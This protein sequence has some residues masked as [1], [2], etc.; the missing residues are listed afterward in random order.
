MQASIPV[1]T[2]VGGRWQITGVLGEGG[3][4]QVLLAVDTSEV[5]LGEAAVKV[6]H[7]GTTPQERADFLTEVKKIAGLRH[8]NL[9]GYLD[10]GQL[11]LPADGVS[12]L[13]D[14]V[15]PFLVTERCAM[16]LSD[17]GRRSS[18]GALSPAE[19]LAVLADVAAGLAHL[20]QQGLI[21][22]DIKPGN[23]LWS[24]GRWKLADFGLMRDLSATG[25]Y[26]RAG[27]LIGTPL[28]MAPELFTAMSATPASD[29]YAMGVLAHVGATGRHLHTG[30]GP[31]LVHN[32]A[33][34]PPAIDPGIH[35]ALHGIVSR[36]THPDPTLR[37]TAAELV[38]LVAAAQR[39]EVP[40]RSAPAAATQVTPG[41]FHYPPASGPPDPA[42][43]AGPPPVS[44]YGPAPAPSGPTLH[45]GQPAATP[46]GYP[47]PAPSGPSGPYNA[48]AGA[49]APPMAPGAPAA[50][51]WPYGPP[52]AASPGGATPS[53]PWG[54][55]G[56]GTPVDGP[57]PAST[58]RPRT[59]VM[60]AGSLA[61]LALVGAMG[62]GLWAATST[63]DDPGQSTVA[64]VNE[65]VVDVPG[66]GVGTPGVST[67]DVQVGN[68]VTVGPGV[69]IGSNA[70]APGAGIDAL[71]HVVGPACDDSAGA[72]PGL[73]QVVNAAD[74][75]VSYS[76]HSYQFDAA[77]V[78]VGEGYDSVVGVA[79]GQ[80][81]W[82]SVAGTDATVVRCEIDSL[83]ATPMPAAVAAGA[84]NV[85]I[86]SCELDTFF[87]D[88]Y[89]ITFTVTNPGTTAMNA[90]VTFSVVDAD[91]A[92]I[93]QSF[94][95]SVYDIPP[96][97]T[98]Q[99]QT[100]D[101]YNNIELAPKPP[102]HCVVSSVSFT[103]P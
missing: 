48:P 59:G 40:A 75:A 101:F 35:P 28:F 14:E 22:R 67:P 58:P 52:P 82:L 13:D 31:I 3:F 34:Q 79:P 99:D 2:L 37:P 90:D 7:P 54:P 39:G 74:T 50:A 47:A 55:P 43:V 17:H 45:S 88:Y 12:R 81:A 18:T 102:D 85:T 6:L 92:I 42:V 11:R 33:T 77:G 41:P 15:R 32:V 44:P 70:T 26:H 16:S 8:P 72:K 87:G 27:T 5:A 25:S 100:G 86:K 4:G 69:S 93:D 51:N 71:S 9:V 94:E 98:V 62:A 21:H 80:A 1:G 63:G 56:S 60:V 89:D 66:G 78:R 49:A 61:G 19:T 95:R 103:T 97:G 38:A 57:P 65:V 91:G 46:Y 30:A 64:D 76:L 53:G 20:H 96:A 29:I 73:I 84:A 23:V 36:C 10:S 68:G 83:S 24:D